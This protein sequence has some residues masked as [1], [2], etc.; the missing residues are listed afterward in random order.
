MEQI[1]IKLNQ[2]K[3][4]LFTDWWLGLKV[5]YWVALVLVATISL[6]WF[7]FFKNKGGKLK[8]SKV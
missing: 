6:T 1:K 7:F 8:K 2:L 4:F 5:V 3:T